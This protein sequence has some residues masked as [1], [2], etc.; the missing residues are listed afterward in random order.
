MH[1]GVERARAEQRVGGHQVVEPVALHR[2]QRLGGERRLELE[3]AGGAA[4]AQHLVDPG[5]VERQRVHVERDAVALRDHGH[6]VVD[7]G[8]RLE[9][10]HVHLEHAD[11]L[12]RAHL[13]LRDD[14][15]LAA[16]AAAGALGRRGAD[17][18]VLRQRPRG[19]HDAGGVH[20]HVRG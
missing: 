18:H 8:E 16:V 7:H 1:A 10:E 6:R 19:D 3:D 17:R 20:R 2:A 15:V 12:Q 4:R 14:G 5:I 11:L 9:A 13:V